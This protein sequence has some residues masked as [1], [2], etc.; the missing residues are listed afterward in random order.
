MI[1]SFPKA[2]VL[3]NKLLST[4]TVHE[5]SAADGDPCKRNDVKGFCVPSDA[6]HHNS[7]WHADR[8]WLQFYTGTPLLRAVCGDEGVVQ[9]P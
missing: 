4:Y 1:L 2:R 7:E 8:G 5:I 3:H 6:D 9:H